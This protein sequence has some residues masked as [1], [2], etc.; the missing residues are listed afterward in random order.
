VYFEIFQL[1]NSGDWKVSLIAER[2]HYNPNSLS[3][4][5]SSAVF[6]QINYGWIPGKNSV[7]GKFRSVSV[8]QKEWGVDEIPDA[9][10]NFDKG[11]NSILATLERPD[12]QAVLS[13]K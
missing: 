2:D 13:V 3:A 5:Q 4:L 8:Y 9:S 12:W 7:F 6:L 11:Y 1:Y 10:G